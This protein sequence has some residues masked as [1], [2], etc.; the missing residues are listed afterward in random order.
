MGQTK[1]L[2]ETTASETIGEGN[3]KGLVLRDAY[4]E[5]TEEGLEDGAHNFT[6]IAL[7]FGLKVIQ[8]TWKKQLNEFC[9]TAAQST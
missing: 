3:V 4:G 5:G 1:K 9:Q 6:G 7:R 2:S 8:Y